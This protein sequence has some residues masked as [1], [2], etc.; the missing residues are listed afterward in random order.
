MSDRATPRPIIWVADDSPVDRQRAERA[1][2]GHY[3]V[4]GFA[5]GSSVLEQLGAGSCPHVL[6]L[7]WVMPGISGIDVVRF[8]RA[9]RGVASEI[10]VLL[11]T[12]QQ[13][14]E[15]ISEGLGAGANDYLAKPYAGEELRA[16]V[17]ALLRS[18]S[19]LERAVR[20][21][22]A[23]R[24]VLFASPDA[25]VALDAEGRVTLANAEAGRVFKCT[26]DELLGAPLVELVPSLSP[27]LRPR[28][29]LGAFP[30]VT[31]GDRIYAPSESALLSDSLQWI[32]SLRDVTERRQ[33]EARRLDL[34]SIAAHDLRTPLGAILLRAEN[35]LA[36]ARGPLDD[37]LRGDIEKMRGGSLRLVSIINDFL[38]LA[39]FEG[40]QIQPRRDPIDLARVVTA[41]GDELRPLAAAK[42]M[43]LELPAAN[44]TLDIFGDQA[45]LSQVMANL[46]S[47]AIKFSP[48]GTAV[49]VTGVDDGDHVEISVVDQGP[50]IPPESIGTLF[51]RFTRVG[52]GSQRTVGTGLG[53][54]IVRQIVE[55]HG[56]HAGVD[57]TPGA[58]SRFWFRV[59]RAR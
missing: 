46:L 51:D 45:R 23:V 40:G 59:P 16:R 38:D 33:V 36:G 7:D 4:V 11:L 49:T 22:R 41:V 37:K 47:N 42:R 50:G 21:E 55:A 43:S 1:L 30:D 56:G 3:A 39:R 29:Q 24:E 26:A 13:R 12:A 19:L 53:L 58:G 35:I 32:V 52:D 9:D 54:M 14:P 20:A 10:P 57:S 5:D 17:A 27:S 18:A 6:V 8:M 25:L 2:E 34:Y 28:G 31:I 44:Q 48:E 15:Q